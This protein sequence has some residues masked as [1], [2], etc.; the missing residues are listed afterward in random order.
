MCEAWRPVE[1]FEKWYEV[2]NEGR[3]KRLARELA[4]SDGV[5]YPVRERVLK[6]HAHPG[7]YRMACL[8]K[9]EGV[10]GRMQYI[11]RLVATAFIPNPRN[12]PEVNHKNLDKTDNR[13]ENLE[14]CDGSRNMRHATKR[15][16]FSGMTNPNTRRK[17]TPDAVEA[18]RQSLGSSYEV[19]KEFGVSSTMVLHIRNG[20]RWADPA[21]VHK[22]EA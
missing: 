17:L 12:L 2:S 20:R 14:W 11:H 5:L 13:V 22:D 6:A 7:G 3:V 21:E 19:A 16:R 9:E 1:G 8:R 15:G 10:N 4:K 18:I